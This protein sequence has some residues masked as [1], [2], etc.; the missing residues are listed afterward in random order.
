[1][2]SAHGLLGLKRSYRLF[3]SSLYTDGRDEWRT[4][5]L[6][7][8]LSAPPKPTRGIPRVNSHRLTG[9]DQDGSG[10]NHTSFANRLQATFPR[11]GSPAIEVDGQK[12]KAD[13]LDL[14]VKQLGVERDRA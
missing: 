13:L 4:D 7:I 2:A 11:C 3:F 14:L 10:G 12:P 5:S 9:A 8:D 6:G 1:M